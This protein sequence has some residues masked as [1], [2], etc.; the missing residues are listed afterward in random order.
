M[1]ERAIVFRAG[2]A[3]LAV[4]AVSLLFIAS[5]AGAL[6]DPRP[7][8]VPVAVDSRVPDAVAEQLG[9]SGEIDVEHVDSA[10]DA[11][12]K[13]DERDVYGAV[14][15]GPRGF[16]VV[17]APAAGPSVAD[18]LRTGLAVQLRRTGEPVRVRVVHRLPSA[19]SRGLVG[20]YTAVGWIV[21]AYLGA[22]FLG[23]I[24]GERPGRRHTVWRLGALAVLALVV[25]FSGA[26]LASAIGDFGGSVALLGLVGA[27]TVMA[28]GA[29]TLAL[30]SL[31]GVV[32]I[33]I[34]VLIFVVLGNPSSGGPFA[35][36][37]LPGFW[38]AVGPLIPTGA[39]TTAIRDIA[40][41]PDA[42]IAGPVLVILAWLVVG[43][44]AA[45]AIGSRRGPL[46]DEEAA[47]TTAAAA[48]P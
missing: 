44:V 18:A 38:R 20:F 31:F 32:G 28:V 17:V 35:T 16:V 10:A 27:L 39:V 9:R 21:G 5:Y 45:L 46:T 22:S 15:A 48:A 1:P 12:R 2:L 42:S 29:V 30:M 34:S 47:A 41:F 4:A 43:V 23:L 13:I 36:E 26:A 14:L 40:Y 24:F 8:D 19:D 3:I 25:G 7:H 37:L 11:L 6:H 33:G